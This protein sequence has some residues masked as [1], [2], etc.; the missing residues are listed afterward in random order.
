M[1]MHQIT[2][3]DNATGDNRNALSMVALQ[4]SRFLSGG[5]TSLQESY[6]QLVSSVGAEARGIDINLQSQAGLLDANEAA[7]SS[8][9]GVNLDE[10]AANLIRFQQAYQASAQVIAVSNTLFDTLL[11]AVRG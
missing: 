10:E 8:V 6:S 11:S 5:T 7:L 9:G 1:I 4:E 3:N 2:N